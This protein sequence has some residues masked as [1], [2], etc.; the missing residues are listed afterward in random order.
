MAVAA[1]NAMPTMANGDASSHAD[2]K[3]NNVLTTVVPKPRKFKASE[4][5]LPSATR[6]AIEELA[7]GFK[8][9]GGY[10]ESRKGVWDFF[11]ASVRA[12]HVHCCSCIVTGHVN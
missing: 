11:E 2:T 10:D 1:V 4:L 7:H 6:S 5:P 3:M 9:K 12:F 8:K